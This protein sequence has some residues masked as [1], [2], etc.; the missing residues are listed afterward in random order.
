MNFFLKKF[1]H[2]ISLRLWCSILVKL[3]LIMGQK[4][5]SVAFW[6]QQQLCSWM[7]RSRIMSNEV[8]VFKKKKKVLFCFEN[9]VIAG[10]IEFCHGSSALWFLAG[11]VIS[12][13][14]KLHIADI[15]LF[16]SDENL[17]LWKETNNCK[18]KVMRETWNSPLFSSPAGYISAIWADFK[19]N[20]L[21][22][23]VH[24][25]VFLGLVYVSGMGSVKFL[26]FSIQ[27]YLHAEKLVILLWSPTLSRGV[28][29]ES[30]AFLTV[31]CK[32]WIWVVP[33]FGRS[34]C[35]FLWVLSAHWS[36]KGFS[37]DVKTAKDTSMSEVNSSIIAG[38]RHRC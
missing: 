18:M 3:H 33:E 8:V 36:V 31:C 16:G 6:S 13:C 15:I 9:D 26:G 17:H 1:W 27:N 23:L 29:G 38:Y 25:L 12:T 19:K 14:V 35:V 28:W 30:S 21:M 2:K 11:E 20:L 10:R 7:S 4:P 24:F 37:R 32:V 22:L 34:F 5:E